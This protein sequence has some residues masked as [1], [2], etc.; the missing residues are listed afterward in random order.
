MCAFSNPLAI[1]MAVLA[2]FTKPLYA[3]Q[4]CW[5]CVHSKNSSMVCNK[6]CCCWC[7]GVPEAIVPHR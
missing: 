6:C 4:P 3:T 5:C 7:N 1:M 2:G